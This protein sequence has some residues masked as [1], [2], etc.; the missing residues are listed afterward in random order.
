MQYQDLLG[1]T[2]G[3]VDTLSFPSLAPSLPLVLD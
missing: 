3:V 2:T 1:L